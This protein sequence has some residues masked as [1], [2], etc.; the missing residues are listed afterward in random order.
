[1]NLSLFAGVRTQ[2]QHVTSFVG[3]VCFQMYCFCRS[4]PESFSHYYVFCCCVLFYLFQF[5]SVCDVALT[6]F[7]ADMSS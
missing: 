2:V 3:Y 1:M 5:L 4:R 6:W 7:V